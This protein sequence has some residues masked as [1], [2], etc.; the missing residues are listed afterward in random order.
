[1]VI[2]VQGDC[3]M[4]W[5]QKTSHQPLLKSSQRNSRSNLKSL[6]LT[7]DGFRRIKITGA[8]G[9]RA[10]CS[11]WNIWPGLHSQRPTVQ[12]GVME[13]ICDPTIRE[14]Q[15][16]GPEVPAHSCTVSLR[17]TRVTWDLVSQNKTRARKLAQQLKEKPVAW[18]DTWAPPLG[19]REQLLGVVL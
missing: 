3:T 8:G 14:V 9:L 17:P 19:R 12:P 11:W 18:T 15:A 6:P 13:C 5:P 16:R 10:E 4:L 1:M 7:K 2:L